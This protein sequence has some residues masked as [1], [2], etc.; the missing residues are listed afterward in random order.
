[1][2]MRSMVEE[3]TEGILGRGKGMCKVMEVRINWYFH[4]KYFQYN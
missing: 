2:N 1:M 3:W 4:R